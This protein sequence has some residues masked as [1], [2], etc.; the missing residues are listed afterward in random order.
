MEQEIYNR[1]LLHRQSE[2]TVSTASVVAKAL[3]LRTEFRNGNPKIL[4]HW[5]YPFLSRYN[6]RCIVPTR[7]GRKINSH[8]VSVRRQFCEELSK[9]I[10]VQQNI[11]GIIVS[12][13][14]KYGWNSCISWRKTKKSHIN[15]WKKTIANE[16]SQSISQGMT[17]CVAVTSH[18]NNLF[19]IFI[20]TGQTDGHIERF[21]KDILPSNTFGRCQL[22]G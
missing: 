4:R 3:S 7:T 8:L 5:V 14:C 21:L 19:L 22:H 9:Q 12:N 16:Y 18:A 15:E 6:L 10:F 17:V 11:S 1:I 2:L 13:V 20:F